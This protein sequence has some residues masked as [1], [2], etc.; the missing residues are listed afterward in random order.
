MTLRPAQ[1]RAARA[2]LNI[3][4]QSLAAASGVS[5]RTIASF[6]QGEHKL[7]PANRAALERA[8]AEAGVEFLDGDGVRLRAKAA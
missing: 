4:R 6:E 8:F 2:L 5:L 7:M 1:C 3:T